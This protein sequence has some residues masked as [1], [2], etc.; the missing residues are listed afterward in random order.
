MRLF[1]LMGSGSMRAD[2]YNA[3]HVGSG[4]ATS[5]MDKNPGRLAGENI[6]AP[7]RLP[8]LDFSLFRCQTPAIGGGCSAY[9]FR[10]A[11]A[12]TRKADCC[13]MSINGKVR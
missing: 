6:I 2:L 12:R 1:N 3:C 4:M 7:N 9:A 11:G 8:R 13:T 10:W 5:R